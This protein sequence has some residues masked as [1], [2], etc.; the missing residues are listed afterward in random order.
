MIAGMW[1][2]LFGH[3]LRT[4]QTERARKLL[5]RLEKD[6]KLAPAEMA[7][8][9]AQWFEALGDSKEA[10]EQY[11]AAITKDPKNVR[12]LKRT[13][14]YYE[15]INLSKAIELLE[16]AVELDAKDDDARLRLAGSARASWVCR[17]LGQIA[18]PRWRRTSAPNLHPAS[19]IMSCVDVFCC[20]VRW[21]RP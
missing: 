4:Q 11:L 12:F 13:A 6:A 19:S 2:L 14:T 20:G 3:F 10:E 8:V 16:N 17:R 9:K 18:G 5:G 7:I 15:R 1:N 21:I